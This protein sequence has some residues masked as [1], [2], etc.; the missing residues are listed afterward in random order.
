M[1][2][3]IDSVIAFS[4]VMLMLSLVVT[5]LVQVISA[6]TDLRGRNLASGLA[7]LMHQ[8]GPELRDKLPDGSTMAEYVADIVVKHPAVAH[9]GTRAKA[10]SQEELVR[11]LRDLC[12][13]RPAASIDETAKTKLKDLLDARVPGGA[14]TVAAARA[15]TDQLGAKFPDLKNEIKV[16]VDG[17]YATVSKLDHQIGLWFDTVMN[18]LSDIFTR[19][20]RVTTVVISLLLVAVLQIDSG[21]ILRQITNNPGL[22]NKLTAMSDT[23]LSQANKIFDNSERAMAALAD[24]KKQNEKDAQL[25]AALGNETPHLTRC[26]DGKNWLIEN[27]KTLPNAEKLEQEFDKACQEETQRA[28]GNSYDQIRGLRSDLE[29]TDLKIIPAVIGGRPVFESRANWWAAYG[30]KR[31]LLGTLISIVFLSLGA[32]FWFNTLRQLSNLK[33][34]I[35]S[36]VG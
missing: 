30:V 22:R 11:V 17:A 33:P 28:M 4:V 20:T 19:R 31:H 32:P 5:A 23:A 24:V 13:E 6:L 3:Q 7:N 18:R 15:V 21:E 27:I 14:E 9:A 36:K 8:I 29:K 25:V 26:V 35:S 10:I 1:L 12:S 2:E 16:T 34:T